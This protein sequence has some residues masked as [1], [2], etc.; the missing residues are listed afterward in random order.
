MTENQAQKTIKESGLDW[1]DFEDWM[2]GQT[3]GMNEDGTE[4]IYDCDVERF[5]RV[6]KRGF[7]YPEEWD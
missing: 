4:D 1:N 7:E 5:I 2:R 6:K 3:F